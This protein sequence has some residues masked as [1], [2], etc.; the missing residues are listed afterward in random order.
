LLG[1]VVEV[2]KCLAFI[3]AVAAAIWA[4]IHLVPLDHTVLRFIM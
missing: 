4:M 2:N 1:A 3:F